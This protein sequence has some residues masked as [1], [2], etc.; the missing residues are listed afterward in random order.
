MFKNYT[1]YTSFRKVVLF[2]VKGSGKTSLTK[3]LETDSFIN[4]EYIDEGN[5]FI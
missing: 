5:I 4:E 2:G 3:R 1:S